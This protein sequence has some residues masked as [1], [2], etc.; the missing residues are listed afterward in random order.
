M[1]LKSGK[2]NLREKNSYSKAVMKTISICYY[3]VK[4]SLAVNIGLLGAVYT[5]QPAGPA[6]VHSA[7]MPGSILFAYEKAGLKL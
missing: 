1:G 4:N 6:W 2:L 3:I 7:A 5:L